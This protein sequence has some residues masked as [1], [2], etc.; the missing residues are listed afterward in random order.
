M[1]GEDKAEARLR[2]LLRDP[3]WSLPAGPDPEQ[4]VRRAARRQRLRHAGMA[5]V[6][7]AAV[8]ALAIPAGLGAFGYQPRPEQPPAAPTLYI[9]SW[10]VGSNHA[11]VVTP[12]DTA[13]NTPGK[14]IDV[15]VGGGPW[16]TGMIVITPDGKTAYVTTAPGPITSINTATG[17][18]GK[19]INIRRVFPLSYG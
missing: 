6:A 7:A 8:I 19:P 16:P 13:T 10:G 3:G 18:P 11:K 12:V 5:G 15:G 14:P 2:E 1:S 4:R 17:M 9:Y